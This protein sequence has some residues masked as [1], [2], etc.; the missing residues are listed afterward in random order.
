MADP[1]RRMPF[2]TIWR[3]AT[4]KATW[5]V[6]LG[7]GES[8]VGRDASVCSIKL[9]DDPYVSARHATFV[10]HAAAQSVFVEDR[11]ST[12]NTWLGGRRITGREELRHGDIL[13]MGETFLLL[14]LPDAWRENTV[15]ATW[16]QP[17]GRAVRVPSDLG[18]VAD[19]VLAVDA[20]VAGSWTGRKRGGPGGLDALL[21]AELG[22]AEDR[23][24]RLADKLADR[25]GVLGRGSDRLQRLADLLRS[26]R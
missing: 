18:N 5:Y 11:R 3:S 12:N 19:A 16:K 4:P 9:V 23:A 13:S 21:A 20:I 24:G 7:D 17:T 14:Q 6:A 15:P 22:V 10:V 25:L 26:G 8:V 2:L 1:D